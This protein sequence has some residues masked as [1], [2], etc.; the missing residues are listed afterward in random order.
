MKPLLRTLSFV[1]L[2]T[3]LM[4]G[5]IRAQPLPPRE[6][7]AQSDRDVL[8]RWQRMTPEEQQQMRERYRRWQNRRHDRRA[9][10]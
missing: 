9:M 10:G 2:M 5:A 3:L 8:E 1:G 7:L 6:R 4:P